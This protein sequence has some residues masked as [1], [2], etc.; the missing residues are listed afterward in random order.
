MGLIDLDAARLAR[1]E[2]EKKPHQLKLNGET[3]ELPPELPAMYAI[4][5]SR[6]NL[7][8]AVLALMGQ[9]QAAKFWALEPSD[10]DCSALVDGV[11][12]TYG[13]TKGESNAS[14][15]PS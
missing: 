5:A 8:S 12:A 9:E 10:D 6:R 2:A 4:H 1:G 14:G 3:F 13:G 11:V 15:E 7:A